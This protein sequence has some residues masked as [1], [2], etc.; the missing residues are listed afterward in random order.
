[1]RITFLWF[2][3][4]PRGHT[5]S[6]VF[7][8][9]KLSVI[10]VAVASNMSE[11][12][13][14]GSDLLFAWLTPIEAN[15]DKK[16]HRP[17]SPNLSSPLLRAKTAIR[18]TFSAGQR[19]QRQRQ[20]G[21]YRSILYNTA[22]TK[23]QQNSIYGGLYALLDLWMCRLSISKLAFACQGTTAPLLSLS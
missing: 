19:A 15:V 22:F 11:Q 16:L 8:A 1:M 13:T 20:Q 10:F 4:Y 21:I 6:V 2:I 17:R 3:N 23:L 18:R 12:N 9:A 14:N 7:E 5:H